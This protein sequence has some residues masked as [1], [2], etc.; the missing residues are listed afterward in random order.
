VIGRS[1]TGTE[2]M[3]K[4][5]SDFLLVVLV[6]VISGVAGVC[7]RGATTFSSIYEAGVVGDV[8]MTIA[9]FLLRRSWRGRAARFP[10]L[11][12]SSVRMAWSRGRHVVSLPSPSE[13]NGRMISL[14]AFGKVLVGGDA[15]AG[16]GAVVMGALEAQG[17][18]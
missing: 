3:R 18:V 16:V 10:H 11:E 17:A 7:G 1:G 8:V 2:W 4:E 14:S 15:V 5:I 9:I 13:S 12:R 6:R